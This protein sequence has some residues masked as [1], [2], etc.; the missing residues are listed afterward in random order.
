M[1]L[2]P[3]LWQRWAA[4]GRSWTH[5]ARRVAIDRCSRCS[6]REWRRPWP[7]P[8]D[9]AQDLRR[10]APAAPPP[11]PAGRRRSGRADD[12]GADLDQLL[13]QRGQRP[14]LDLLRQGQRAQEV[15]EVV[16]QGV[17]LE[18]HG[19]VAEGMAAVRVL[20]EQGLTVFEGKAFSPQADYA[21]ASAASIRASGSRRPRRLPSSRM[22]RSSASNAVS[23]DPWPKAARARP[24]AM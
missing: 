16:G 5:L 7:Q 3:H 10:T 15:G 23:Q 20:G 17:E 21:P 24:R 13:A 4:L 18:P 2:A 12:P 8:I 22:R 11:R 9:P 19:V 6:C 14:L 1:R